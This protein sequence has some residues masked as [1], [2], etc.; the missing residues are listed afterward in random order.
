MSPQL[1]L[2]D[3]S[4]LAWR[5]RDNPI[6]L[7][8]C[9]KLFRDAGG[10]GDPVAIHGERIYHLSPDYPDWKQQPLANAIK[11]AIVRRHIDD[12]KSAIEAFSSLYP[13][14]MVGPIYD[15][16]FCFLLGEY[17]A[18]RM[19]MEKYEEIQ[20]VKLVRLADV[21]IE[22]IEGKPGRFDAL[23]KGEKLLTGKMLQNLENYLALVE[24]LS[25]V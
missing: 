15:F 19:L 4:E 11:C 18:C 10:V 24:V 17:E 21:V 8:A 3:L 6:L 22:H 2:S 25:I 23:T 7:F 9:L 5:C 14:S 1:S 16:K 13:S 20:Q 12:G